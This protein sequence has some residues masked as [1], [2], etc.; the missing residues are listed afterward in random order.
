VRV[1]IAPQEFKGSFGADEAAAAIAS[2]IRSARPEW[3]LDILPMSDGGPGLLDAMRR[4][5]KADTMAAIVR[6]ALGREVLG[7]Y[8]RVRATGDV[9]IEAAQANGLFHLRPEERNAVAADSFGVGELMADAAATEP[10]RMLIG[11]GGSATTDGG[12]GALRA[13]GAKFFDM[14]GNELSPGGGPLARLERIEWTLPSWLERTRVVVATDVTNPLCGPNGAAR[15]YAPQKGATPEE[16]D[17]LEEA[18]FKFANVVRRHFGV[19]AANLPGGGAAGGLALG[20]AVFLGAPIQSGFDVVAGAVGLEQ[21]L[22]AAGIVV[23]GEG[24]FDGQSS[25]GKVT[26]RLLTLAAEREKPCIVFAGRSTEPGAITLSSRASS[27]A[28]AMARAAELLTRAAR[29]WAAAQ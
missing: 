6:D 26:G 25:Q 3:E 10:S 17:Q 1:L 23:T 16:V 8:I 14:A 9:V 18:L 22:E 12:A 19:D 15:I 7:R 11:V 4:A 20:L 29:E 21:R 28:D 5:V 24:S 2:G 27:E 13:L